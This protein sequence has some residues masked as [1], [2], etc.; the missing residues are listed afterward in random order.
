MTGS[1]KTTHRTKSKYKFYLAT[2]QAYFM[3]HY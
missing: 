3:A 1:E 2:I